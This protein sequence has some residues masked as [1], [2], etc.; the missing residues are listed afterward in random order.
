MNSQPRRHYMGSPMTTTPAPLSMQARQASMLSNSLP[1]VQALR[2]QTVVIVYA[3]SAV[4]DH[5]A[6]QVFAQ[7][8]ALLALMGVQLVVVHGGTPDFIAQGTSQSP[9]AEATLRV[10]RTVL[11]EVN[12]ELVRLINQH[13]PKALGI[14]GQ[15]G[16]CMTAAADSLADQ[17]HAV[18]MLDASLFTSFLSNGLLPVVMPMAPDADGH[19]QLLQP[20]QLGNVLAQRLQAATLVLMGEG[21]VLEEIR[22]LAVTRNRDD[23][24]RWQAEAALTPASSTT[25][26]ALDALGHGVQTVHMIDAHEPNSLLNELLTDE[27]CGVVLCRRS[28]A[29]LLADSTRYFH[30]SDSVLRPDFRAERKLVVR[31]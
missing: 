30:D 31:F 7:D 14:A 8:V 26:V 4:H 23:L 25:S 10:S 3:G 18:S 15:D 13:G 24:A 11:A 21:A 16:R 9:S 29:Q 22:A 19:D 20:Q 5:A 27:G 1:F 28:S 17:L 12:M 2:H 6:R